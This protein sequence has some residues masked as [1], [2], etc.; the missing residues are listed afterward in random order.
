MQALTISVMN[1]Y[2]SKRR[3]R[4]FNEKLHI[5]AF[6]LLLTA[7]INFVLLHHLQDALLLDDDQGKSFLAFSHE[8]IAT[9]RYPIDENILPKKLITVIGKESSGTT[10]VAKTIATA[11]N[12]PGE[13]KYR[14]GFF[15][16]ERY[17]GNQ[18]QVQHVSL[19]QGGWCMQNHS[20]QIVD[21]ILPA[22]CV[23]DKHHKYPGQ[24]NPSIREQ[25]QHFLNSSSLQLYEGKAELHGP[26]FMQDKFDAQTYYG[27]VRYP[28]RV[29]AHSAL[30]RSQNVTRTR[31]GRMRRD[32]HHHMQGKEAG[33]HEDTHHEDRHHEDRHVDESASEEDEPNMNDEDPEVKKKVYEF[34]GKQVKESV[35][36][37]PGESRATHKH[38]HHQKEDH[39]DHFGN[40]ETP[41]QRR[42]RENQER[43]REM[44][45]E[46][47]EEMEQGEHGVKRK[48]S[49][50]QLIQTWLGN[51]NNISLDELTER[52]LV[53]YPT[54]FLL[55]ITTQKIWYDAHGT[56]QIIVI[57]VRDE[58]ISF[59]SRL[60]AHCH[61]VELAKEEEGIATAILNDAIKTFF[62]D[63]K[64]GFQSGFDG[65]WTAKTVH[66]IIQEASIWDPDLMIKNKT[67]PNDLLHS[68][69]I[70][71]NNNVVLVSYEAMMKYEQ[72]Y[73]QELYKVLG[74]ESQFQ[75]ELK[76]GN[77][78][79]RKGYK[80]G[81]DMDEGDM[82]PHVLKMELYGAKLV[83]PMSVWF[84]AAVCFFGMGCVIGFWL[85]LFRYF[86]HL[87]YV[88][89][90]SVG[91][92]R[93]R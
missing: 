45:K 11:L 8:L 69:L 24:M 18:I 93:R 62:L 26:W 84:I 74:I 83:L 12:L 13:Q 43:K 88:D 53:K 30:V 46:V 85:L 44:V 79:Y 68:S 4:S 5:V 50:Q 14:D 19:P 61:V 72:D 3:K 71:A 90:H 66:G 81:G 41:N 76:D 54:R 36:G 17:D 65:R 35:I 15:H 56:E 42:R 67:D 31:N 47:H 55:N 28:G 16:H 91:R 52:N 78:K 20:H 1:A 32:R 58:A 6:C 48:G 59:Q 29:F 7:V 23:Q 70:P 60:K 22:Q 49:K 87:T 34:D 57:V 89:P 39:Y 64:S 75:P 38:P 82:D 63:D 80:V 27:A 37:I 21:V 40:E 10:I 92:G 9:T 73:V 86:F 51:I 33:R 77:A 25:C 2:S